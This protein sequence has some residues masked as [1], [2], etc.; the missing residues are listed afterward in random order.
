MVRIPKWCRAISSRKDASPIEG[1]SR[2]AE[3]DRALGQGFADESA[4]SRRGDRATTGSAAQ[5]P[6]RDSEIAP[7]PQGRLLE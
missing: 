6:R 2:G 3:R 4:L 7:P 1:F 5:K